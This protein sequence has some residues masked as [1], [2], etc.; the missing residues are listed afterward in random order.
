MVVPKKGTTVQEV[1]DLLQQN[2]ISATVRKN[3]ETGSEFLI[4]CDGSVT[5][6]V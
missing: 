5:E 4:E 3:S 6:L 1:E 2:N